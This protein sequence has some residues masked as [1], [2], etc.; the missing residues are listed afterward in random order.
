MHVLTDSP[1][2]RPR[3][4]AYR[5]LLV[6]TVLACC[7]IWWVGFIAVCEWLWGLVL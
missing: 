2:E 7:A 6:P 1:Y 3:S 5:L 4:R